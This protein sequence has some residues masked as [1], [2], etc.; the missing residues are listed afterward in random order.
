MTISLTPEKK[1]NIKKII[2]KILRIHKATIRFLANIIGSLVVSLPG[3]KFGR[4]HYRQ[5]GSEKDLALIKNNSNFD[6]T[7]YL[8]H[9]AKNELKWWLKILHNLEIGFIHQLFI[10][11]CIVM[12]LTRHGF[13]FSTT[14][15]WRPI[16]HF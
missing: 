10:H 11:T 8:T 7:L 6:A 14:E 12:H 16:G 4:L 3:V 5:L 1:A 15:N 13:K 2:L 9:T